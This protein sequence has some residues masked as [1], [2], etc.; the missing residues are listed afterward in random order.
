MDKTLNIPVIAK[1]LEIDP[2]VFQPLVRAMQ[3]G[4]VKAANKKLD[5]IKVIVRKRRRHLAKK[6]HPDK[7][8]GGD[9]K[10]KEINALI[11]ML[12]KTRIV[13]P[14]R[15]KPTVVMYRSSFMYGGTT[16]ATDTSTTT[17]YYF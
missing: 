6:Y 2:L 14:P 15:P 8:G 5:K 11:D 1:I 7:N 12:L 17:T 3:H 10:I 16:S 4:E 13:A 9:E